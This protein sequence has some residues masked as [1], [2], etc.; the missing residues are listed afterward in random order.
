MDCWINGLLG[1]DLRTRRN[2]SGPVLRFALCFEGR[3][4][5]KKLILNFIVKGVEPFKILLIEYLGS[6][7]T[8]SPG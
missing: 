5:G 1:G 2:Y 3:N 7:K 8:S 6:P 4:K